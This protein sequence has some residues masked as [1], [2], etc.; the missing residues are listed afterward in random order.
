MN[1]V[2]KRELEQVLEG[3]RWSDY[4]YFVIS[5]D[6]EYDIILPC[7]FTITR[8]QLSRLQNYDFKR[9]YIKYIGDNIL[10]ALHF[11]FDE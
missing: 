10:L 11:K 9:M 7:S 1:W 6:L 8:E 5:D 4:A 3:W 2:K